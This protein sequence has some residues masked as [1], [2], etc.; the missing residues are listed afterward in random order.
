[1]NENR[2]EV[3][4]ERQ[5]VALITVLTGLDKITGDNLLGQFR[6]IE[7]PFNNISELEQLRDV[8]S[9]TETRNHIDGFFK[10]GVVHA[11]TNMIE[12]VS[13]NNMLSN[14]DGYMYNK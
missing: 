10:L 3:E 1:M 7:T 12:L 6:A 5:A 4:F 9:I 11:L 14:C 2:L 8:A 13:R